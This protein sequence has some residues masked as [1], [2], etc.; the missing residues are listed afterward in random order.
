MIASHLIELLRCPVTRQR[1]RPASAEL[2]AFLES[3]RLAGRLLDDSGNPV[4]ESIESGLLR[5]DGL[6]FYPIRN[7]I[8]VMVE[9]VPVVFSVEG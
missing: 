7:G 4:R 2:V 8:P 1:L 5:E 6:A 9:C 3:E